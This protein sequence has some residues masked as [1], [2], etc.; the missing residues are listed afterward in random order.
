M[1]CVSAERQREAKQRET[2]SERKRERERQIERESKQKRDRKR[3]VVCQRDEG[4]REGEC[5]CERERERRGLSK[6]RVSTI[7]GDRLPRRVVR[8]SNESY[9]PDPIIS[10]S[11]LRVTHVNR[12]RPAERVRAGIGARGR[13]VSFSM[14][15]YYWCAL[16]LHTNIH[17]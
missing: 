8:Y 17:V 4:R 10:S 7:G 16:G 14:A 12:A 5:V 3:L 2:D 11:S 9:S 6:R 1:R 15:L 13:N